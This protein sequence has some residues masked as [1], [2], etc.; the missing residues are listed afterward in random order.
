MLAKN[1][2]KTLTGHDMHV[3]LPSDPSRGGRRLKKA[4]TSSD[5]ILQAPHVV[6]RSVQ[7]EAT[8]APLKGFLCEDH[9]HSW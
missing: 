1:A 8:A 9:A 4:Q 5:T 7:F 3:G 2:S 6:R